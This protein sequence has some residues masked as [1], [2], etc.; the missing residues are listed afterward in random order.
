MEAHKGIME[1]VNEYLGDEENA[2]YF[3]GKRELEQKWAN[4]MVLKGDYSEK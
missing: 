1:A 2:F 3:E 4:C